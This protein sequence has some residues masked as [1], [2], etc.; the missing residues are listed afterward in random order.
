MSADCDGFPPD[1]NSGDA[2][3]RVV[4]ACS[5]SELA[6][7]ATERDVPKSATSALSSVRRMLLGERSACMM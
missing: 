5:T 3:V 1:I 6:A 2:T 7:A 4:T